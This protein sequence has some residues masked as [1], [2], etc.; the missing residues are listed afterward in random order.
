MKNNKGFS[1]IELL[2]VIL[3][4]G[5]LASIAIGGVMYM[6]ET[7]KEN[8]YKTQE[9]LLIASARE[10]YL[11][12]RY[13]LPDSGNSKTLS[14]NTLLKAGYVDDIKDHN[15]NE[16]TSIDVLIKHNVGTNDYEYSVKWNCPEYQN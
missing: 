8:Y 12:N 1:L 7:A 3:I 6:L 11:N 14:T 10:Y 4:I 13:D 5:I 2:A 15:S 16:C 9:E